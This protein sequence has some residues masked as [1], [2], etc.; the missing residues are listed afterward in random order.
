MNE[1][2]IAMFLRLLKMAPIV[3]AMVAAGGWA[4]GWGSTAAYAQCGCCQHGGSHAGHGAGS[5]GHQH[6]ATTEDHAAHDRATDA[7]RPAP[8]HGGQLTIAPPMS[9]EVVYLPQEIRVYL[10]GV[11]P[12]PAS[13]K[14]VTGEVAL[15]RPYDER[16]TRVALHYVGQPAGQQDYLQAPVDL[17][18]VK[19]GELTANVKLANLPLANRP[20]ITF[21]QPVAVSKAKPFVALAALGESDRAGI[22]RQGVCPVTGAALDSMGGPVKVL[23]GGQPLYLCCKGCLGKVQSAPE[24]YLAKAAGQASQVQ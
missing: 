21:S 19:D 12:N 15:Q 23:V 22:S 8:P 1:G 14:D 7:A 2:E 5:A 18:R 16:A 20:G 6:G 4:L 24:A 17:G 9:F 3:V 11:V 10:Y 13:A